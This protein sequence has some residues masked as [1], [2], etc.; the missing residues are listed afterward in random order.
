MLL[1][2][3]PSGMLTGDGS[4]SGQSEHVTGLIL[5]EDDYGENL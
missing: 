5:K 1:A 2:R 3:T 4:G